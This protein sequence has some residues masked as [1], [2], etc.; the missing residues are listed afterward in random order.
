MIG[1]GHERS[2][3][4]ISFYGDETLTVGEEGCTAE[5]KEKEKVRS[6]RGI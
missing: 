4:T 3:Y 2:L 5:V 6:E 1:L